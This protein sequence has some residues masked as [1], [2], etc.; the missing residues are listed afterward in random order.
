MA[1]LRFLQV[2]SGLP[3]QHT[4]HASL[5]PW[6]SFAFN[7][8]RSWVLY[9]K[10]PPNKYVAFDL[11]TQCVHVQKPQKSS[12]FAIPFQGRQ[13]LRLIP[14]YERT[15]L[16]LFFKRV[17]LAGSI[18]P[19]YYRIMHGPYLKLFTSGEVRRCQLKIFIGN[20]SRLYTRSTCSRTLSSVLNFRMTLWS[21][22][23]L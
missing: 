18:V 10:L 21:V 9:P 8:Q 15:T 7:V 4:V 11:Q 16:I 22:A 3:A 23:R 17:S 12:N 1:E 20:E 19:W 5:Q 14:L 6:T 13:N 2:C